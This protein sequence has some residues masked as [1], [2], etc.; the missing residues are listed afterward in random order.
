[1]KT[2][3]V[4]GMGRF[5]KLLATRMAELGNE[6]MAVDKEEER[7]SDV[8]PIV[9][10][11]QIGDCMQE[12]MLHTL[13]VGN[14]DICFVCMGDNFQASLEITSLLA[15]LGAR[16]VVSKVDRDIH[17]KFLLR[18]GADEVIYPE[19]DIA[20]RAAIKYSAN[21]VFDFI[22]LSDEFCI[23]EIEAPEG[24]MGKSI[25]QV[26]VRSK[27]KINIIAIKQDKKIIPVTSAEYV[28]TPGEHLIIAGNTRDGARLLDL[29]HR[30]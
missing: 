13:G 7:L 20:Q 14:F 4:I 6:V 26:N 3:L 10:R 2:V 25:R 21:N 23:F 15:D 17:A 16:H 19:R 30:S 27:Y 11:A 18:N 5:G 9:T 29:K 28:F 8:L 22:A 1:M 12:S 24:W